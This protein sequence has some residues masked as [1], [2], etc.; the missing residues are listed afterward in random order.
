[1]SPS[2]CVSLMAIGGLNVPKY[3]LKGIEI[4]LGNLKC[5]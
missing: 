2:L 3:P 1:M 5:R 4:L